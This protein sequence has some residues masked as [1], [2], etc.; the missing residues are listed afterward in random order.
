MDRIARIFDRGGLPKGV[1][2]T[3]G[4][5]ADRED[6]SQYFEPH[7]IFPASPSDNAQPQIAPQP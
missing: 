7:H 2:L 6:G 4:T 5:I 3:I 1:T